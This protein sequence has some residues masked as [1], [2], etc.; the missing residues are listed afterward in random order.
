MI[1]VSAVPGRF[2]QG[3][4]LTLTVHISVLTN[5]IEIGFF[6]HRSDCVLIKSVNISTKK[7]QNHVSGSLRNI[8]LEMVT[9]MYI[10]NS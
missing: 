10:I 2:P 1:L 4:K 5:P 3:K 8:D 7:L 6:L 9:T